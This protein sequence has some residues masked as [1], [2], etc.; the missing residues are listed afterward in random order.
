MPHYN[1][2][3]WPKPRWRRACGISRRSRRRQHPGER[4]VGGADEDAGG[5]ASAISAIFS[6]GTSTTRPSRNVTLE[7]VGGSAL[8]L[9]SDLSGGVSGRFTMWT[10]ATTSS[11]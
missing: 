9:L 1:V 2:R 11:G 7:D 3:A 10:A 4:V 6:S 5:R 8:Y